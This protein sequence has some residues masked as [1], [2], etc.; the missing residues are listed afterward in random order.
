MK[1]QQVLTEGAVPLLLL[2]SVVGF[3][4]SSVRGL[5]YD[6]AKTFPLALQ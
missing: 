4:T 5:H 1:G 2:I 6:G 3:F